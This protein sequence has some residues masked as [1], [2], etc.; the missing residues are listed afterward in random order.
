MFCPRH[1]AVA[2]AFRWYQEVLDDFPPR[3]R[4]KG[5]AHAVRRICCRHCVWRAA[6]ASAVAR[7]FRRDHAAKSDRAAPVALSTILH[8]VDV[9]EA[10]WVQGIERKICP[11]ALEQATES[12]QCAASLRIVRFVVEHLVP[13]LLDDE[14]DVG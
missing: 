7:V 11:N 6:S 9:Q 3:Q 12:D 10:D 5:A 13:L 4:V 2:L 14:A 8:R 1:R